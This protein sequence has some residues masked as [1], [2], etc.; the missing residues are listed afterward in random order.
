MEAIADCFAR[1]EIRNTAAEMVTGLLA[2]VRFLDEAVRPSASLDAGTQAFLPGGDGLGR[3]V[4]GVDA[5]VGSF[6]VGPEVPGRCRA[7]LSAWSSPVGGGV[8]RGSR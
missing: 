4:Q 1:R 2:E 3:K 7:R 6:D 8:L 5:G